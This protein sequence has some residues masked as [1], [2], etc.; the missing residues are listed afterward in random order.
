VEK[1]AGGYLV[2]TPQGRVR[3]ERLVLATNAYQHQWRPFRSR[4]KPVWSYAMVSEPLDERR[5]EQVHWPQ[6]EGFVE[7]RNFIV[8][9]RLTA[10]NRLLLGGGP[11]PYFYGRDMDEDH[12]RSDVAVAALREALTRYFPA[13][14]DLRFT[15]AYGGCIAVTR[16]LVPHVG[17]GSDGILHAYGYCGN[18]IAMTHTAGK[19]LRD[20][21][22]GKDSNYS[23][24]LFVRGREPRFPPEPVAYAGVK[25]LSALLGWQDRHPHLLKR[26][27]V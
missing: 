27:L 14:S 5:L 15:H 18:G 6:R 2:R 25:G 1:V 21:V 19:A 23:Q 8:F 17:E 24:L 10:Q 4:V 7:A 13:W 9:G 16:D 20:L 11:A 22:L 26:Q 3:A 12:I